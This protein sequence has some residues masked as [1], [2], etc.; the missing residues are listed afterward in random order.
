MM[1]RPICCD[2]LVEPIAFCDGLVESWI[3]PK[4]YT[5]IPK[6][7]A[8][9]GKSDVSEQYGNVQRRT[10][11]RTKRTGGVGGVGGG[12]GGA[13][14]GPRRNLE[15]AIFPI[16]DGLVSLGFESSRALNY[17]SIRIFYWLQQGYT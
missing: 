11:T 8:S 1:Q 5:F 13:H 15:Q 4:I 6:V 9:N 2:I 16:L 12:V 7:V 17:Y 10:R 14:F 3:A